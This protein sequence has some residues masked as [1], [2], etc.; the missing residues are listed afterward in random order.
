MSRTLPQLTRPLSPQARGLLEP[1]SP[2]LARTADPY[3]RAV[4]LD[5][6]F[7]DAGV[8]SGRVVNRGR[9]GLIATA[10][11][12]GARVVTRPDFPEPVLYLPQAGHVILTI[13]GHWFGPDQ[14]VTAEVWV[15][16]IQW[17]NDATFSSAG[18]GSAATSF[19]LMIHSGVPCF[20]WY[21]DGI[22]PVVGNRWHHFAAS[23][24][25][26]RVMFWWDGILQGVLTNVTRHAQC[27]TWYLGSSEYRFEGYVGAVRVTLAPRYDRPFHPLTTLYRARAP[28]GLLPAAAAVRG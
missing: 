5:A 15:Y 25:R 11:N 13:A 2:P 6:R 1:V 17:P 7:L 10:F 9:S 24:S 3:Q 16:P 19:G 27:Q 21:A 4:V 14:D 23:R 12:G 26:G 22:T 20:G 18:T 28:G 8:G